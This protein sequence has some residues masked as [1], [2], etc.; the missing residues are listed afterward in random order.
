MLPYFILPYKEK[1]MLQLSSWRCRIL[2]IY[3]D[4]TP[5]RYKRNIGR[6]SFISKFS[7][8]QGVSLDMAFPRWLKYAI[9]LSWI[10]ILA[11]SATESNLVY[12]RCM[13][14]LLTVKKMGSVDPKS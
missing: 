7:C 5:A 6:E 9:L 8:S 14:L 1:E 3:T 4:I 10:A 12:E 2:L 13:I 11:K